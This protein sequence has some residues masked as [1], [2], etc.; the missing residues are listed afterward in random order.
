MNL[1]NTQLFYGLKED[2]ITSLLGCLNAEKT[3]L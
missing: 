3:Q 2:E 1:S